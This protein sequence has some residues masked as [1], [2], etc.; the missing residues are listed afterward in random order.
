M[1]FNHIFFCRRY[2]FAPASP[3]R[4]RDIVRPSIISTEYANRYDHEPVR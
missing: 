2:Q 4:Q 3:L 1:D